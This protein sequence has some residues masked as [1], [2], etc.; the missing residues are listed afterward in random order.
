LGEKG[1]AR[2]LACPSCSAGHGLAEQDFF[3]DT[4]GI[5]PLQLILYF[6][7]SR[8]QFQMWIEIKKKGIS[9]SRKL[10]RMLLVPGAEIMTDDYLRATSSIGPDN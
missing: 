1:V 3:V 8:A 5:T 4:Q 7:L 10:T 9:C 2:K 6:S